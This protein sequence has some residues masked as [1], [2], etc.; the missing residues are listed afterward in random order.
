MNQ[1]ESGAST[2]TLSVDDAVPGVVRVHFSDPSGQATDA[3]LHVAQLKDGIAVAGDGPPIPD[4][5]LGV[6]AVFFLPDGTDPTSLG[7]TYAWSILPEHDVAVIVTW[8]DKSGATNLRAAGLVIHQADGALRA[9]G[10]L[11]DEAATDFL[12]SSGMSGGKPEG[13]FHMTELDDVHF[14]EVSVAGFRGFAE[15]RALSLAVPNG[16]RGSGLTIVVGANNSGKSTFIES[17]HAIARARVQNELSFPQPHR[18]HSTD[19]VEVSIRRSDGRSLSVA[20]TRPGG[21]QAEAKW[22]PADG[23]PDRFDI[24]VTPS[25]RS[26]NPYFGNMGI[27]DR[28]WGLTSQEFSRT[29]LRDQFVGRL[30]KVDRDDD[31]RKAFDQLLDEIVGYH[32]SWTIDEI[33]TGQ[34]FLKLTDVTGAWHTSEGLGDGLVSLLFIVDALY[35]SV[36]GSLIAIDEPE[37][38]LHPQL[39][40]RLG[41]VLSRFA[42]DRQV[43][44]AT[45]SP[46]LL[47]WSDVAN[48]AAVARVHKSDGRSE[49]SQVSRE[50]LVRVA[51]LADTKNAANP[52]T[53]GVVAREAFFLED[54]VILMEGQDDVA[55]L[56]RILIDLELPPVDNVYGWGSGGVGNIPTLATLFIELGFTRIAAILDDDGQASTLSAAEKLEA[57]SPAVLVVQI[58]AP[59]IRYKKSVSPRDEILGLLDDDNK[60]VRPQHRE[61]AREVLSRAIAHVRDSSIE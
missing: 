10:L 33:T 39:V 57:L 15:R 14:V 4:L 12:Q 35:D 17:L 54:G 29:E 40:R 43:V 25:R 26:F 34:Q 30:R 22:V 3:R 53:V 56:P 60:Q 32:L 46:Q 36:P 20:S 21:S 48:G 50:T 45:H 24:H 11:W 13:Q 49:I 58:P 61:A 19:A 1:R 23:G 6:A 47:E 37:L 52:H 44:V 42:A 8:R 2:L 28:N 38:S 31:A 27:V 5:H 18:H 51:K 59:D 9:G 41:R 55:Y 16:Q 7:T